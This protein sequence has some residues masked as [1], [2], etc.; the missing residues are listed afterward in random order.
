MSAFSTA[1]TFGA[2]HEL[3]FGGMS[4]TSSQKVTAVRSLVPRSG[5]AYH[6]EY[7]PLHEEDDVPEIPDHE[8]QVRYARDALDAHFSDWFVTGNVCI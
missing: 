1:D 8:A 6:Q 3:P 5:R 2:E 7:Y 4:S